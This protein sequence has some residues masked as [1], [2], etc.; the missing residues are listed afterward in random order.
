MN[1]ITVTAD[2]IKSVIVTL[3]G[4]APANYDSM[5][6]LVAVVNYLQA[7]LVQSEEEKEVEDG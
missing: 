5:D 7:L 6:R 1:E 3:K 4:I 2:N